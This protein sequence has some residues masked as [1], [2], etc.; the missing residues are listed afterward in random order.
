[1][2]RWDVVAEGVV[3]VNLTF[4]ASLV[5]DVETVIHDISYKGDKFIARTLELTPA[6]FYLTGQEPVAFPDA[7]SMT[8]WMA[9]FFRGS[10]EGDNNRSPQYVKDAI[11]AYKN[12]SHMST[13]RGRAPKKINIESLGSLDDSILAQVDAAELSNLQATLARI[14]SARAAAAEA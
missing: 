10:G 5:P 14:L 4:D 1:M 6:F 7:G 12:R 8:A 11:V 3:A 13:R 2:E 9:K